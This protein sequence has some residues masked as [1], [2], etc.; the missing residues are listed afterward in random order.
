M[1]TTNLIARHNDTQVAFFS[2]GNFK[3]FNTK[4]RL[5]SFIFLSIYTV[6][7]SFRKAPCR[8]CG[9]LYCKLNESRFMDV[10]LY[11]LGAS[12]KYSML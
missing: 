6:V 12:L 1:L 2:C 5:K 7:W 10:K 4:R 11:V 8:P 3:N 9:I